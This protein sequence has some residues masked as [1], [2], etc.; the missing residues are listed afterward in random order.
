V[1]Q[2]TYDSKQISLIVGTKPLTGLADGSFVTVR[3][4]SDAFTTQVGADGEPVRSKTNDRSGEYEF[5]LMQGSD[6]NDFMSELALADE[7]SNGGVIPVLVK[8]NL[9]NSLY[10]SESAWIKKVPDSEFAKENGQR[11][12]IMSSGNVNIFVGKSNAA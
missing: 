5:V 6:E 10:V 3:R 2:K 12:W 1:A 9:G 4:N 8:D 11:T 7:L